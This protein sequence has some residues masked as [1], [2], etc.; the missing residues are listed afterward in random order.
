[1][2]DRTGRVKTR[3]GFVTKITSDESAGLFRSSPH[4]DT[5][6]SH[7]SNQSGPSP[8]FVYTPSYPRS[9]FIVPSGYHPTLLRSLLQSLLFKRVPEADPQSDVSGP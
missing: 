3:K 1:M 8:T 5:S 9:L 6:P 4:L 2:R 7:Q